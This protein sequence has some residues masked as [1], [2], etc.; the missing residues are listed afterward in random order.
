ME[1]NPDGD[2]AW[3]TDMLNILVS[4]NISKTVDEG[5]VK[6]WQVSLR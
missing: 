3:F 2:V 5:I 6:A 4:L 1:I